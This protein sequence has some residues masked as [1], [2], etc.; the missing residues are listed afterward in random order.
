MS[1]A[2]ALAER[3]SA[4]CSKIARQHFIDSQSH[5]AAGTQKV[6]ESQKI[7]VPLAGVEPKF[8]KFIDNLGLEA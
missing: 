8:Y 2:N 3:F 1:L 4:R 5:P 6:R 7:Q